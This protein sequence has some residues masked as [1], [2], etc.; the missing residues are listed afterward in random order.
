MTALQSP[1]PNA[2]ALIR[3]SIDRSGLTIRKYANTVV[4]RSERTVERWIDG[5]NTMP[6]LILQRLLAEH[7]AAG[8]P[9]LPPP[10]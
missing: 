9:P 8:S 7:E 2:A 6:R 10:R 4:L 5:E 3:W 1:R